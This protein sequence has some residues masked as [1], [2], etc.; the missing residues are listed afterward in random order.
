M[1]QGAER[2]V[3]PLDRVALAD[4]RILDLGVGVEQPVPATIEGAPEERL[5]QPEIG[6]LLPLPEL[7]SEKLFEPL[8]GEAGETPAGG[9]EIAQGFLVFGDGLHDGSS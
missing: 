4:D 7:R 6:H 1:V 3:A 5:Q 9:Q 2:R 8:G